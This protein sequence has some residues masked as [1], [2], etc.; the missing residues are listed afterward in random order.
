MQL[1]DATVRLG[2]SVGHTVEKVNLTPA[3]I[4]VLRRIHGT[5]AVLNIYPRRSDKRSQN[6]E[7]TR[8]EGLYG[9][10][11]VAALFPG[12]MSKLPT[13]LKDIGLAP[14][15]TPQIP[16]IELDQMDEPNDDDLKAMGLDGGDGLE[17]AVPTQAAA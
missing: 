12:E 11:I 3:E 7:R 15:P 2:G 5:D 13:T 4:A 10:E 16:P 6:G 9:A 1:C 8:L 14:S 17:G